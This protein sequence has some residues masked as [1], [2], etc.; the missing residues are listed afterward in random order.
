MLLK[1]RKT[2]ITVVYNI[3]N[4]GRIDLTPAG[5]CFR[6]SAHQRSVKDLCLKAASVFWPMALRFCF[7]RFANMC[8]TFALILA[9]A[10]D[11]VTSCLER[12]F[13][14][15]FSRINQV[16]ICCNRQRRVF[17]VLIAFVSFNDI[18]QNFIERGAAAFTLCL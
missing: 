16:R 11:I 5:L 3:V 13:Y 7:R 6:S 8:D 2:A 4:M 1:S 15:H 14:I 9:R 12:R 17:A 10:F 18:G